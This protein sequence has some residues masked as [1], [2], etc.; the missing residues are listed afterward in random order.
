MKY[1]ILPIFI[2]SFIIGIVANYFVGENIIYVYPNPYNLNDY[3]IKDN[4]GKCFQYE[5]K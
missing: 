1:I 4:D 2:I 5:L 3:V